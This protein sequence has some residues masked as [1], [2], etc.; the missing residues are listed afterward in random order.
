VWITCVAFGYSMQAS[1]L[2]LVGQSQLGLGSLG[3]GIF[4]AVIAVG[5]VI[6]ALIAPMFMK[7]FNEFTLIV[8]CT[9]FMATFN[10]LAATSKNPVFVTVALAIDGIS[11]MVANITT[12]SLRQRLAPPN[13]VGR[14]MATSKMLVVGIQVLGAIVG[15]VII[16]RINTEAA[17]ATTCVIGFVL[18]ATKARWLRE[19]MNAPGGKLR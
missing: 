6:G 5:N 10:G 13:M 7:R 12:F 11:V 15:G 2:V 19:G 3:F 14:I 16:Q 17:L 4:S 8:F 1:A 9:I 18:T